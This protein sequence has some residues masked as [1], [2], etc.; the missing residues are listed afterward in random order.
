MT[1]LPFLCIEWDIGA[2]P[3][4]FLYVQLALPFFREGNKL[5]VSFIA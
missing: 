1:H 4:L 5:F 3:L 2:P